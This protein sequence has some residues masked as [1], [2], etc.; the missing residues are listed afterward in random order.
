MSLLS[1]TR[2]WTCSW[3]NIP[4]QTTLLEQAQTVLLAIKNNYVSAGWT[5][6][7]SSNASAAG[8]DAVDRWSTI[9]DLAWN[10]AGNAHSWIVLRSPANYPSASG[11]IWLLLSCSPAVA[12]DYHRVRVTPASSAFSGGSTTASP[13]AGA[14]A[15]TGLGTSGVVQFLNSVLTPSS[16]HAL[17]NT[18]GD[19]MF[20]VSQQ[21]ASYAATSWTSLQTTGNEA[22]DPYPWHGMFAYS[23][24]AP[25][26]FNVDLTDDTAASI[27]FWID[28]STMASS[29]ITGVMRYFTPSGGS[30]NVLLSYFDS[31]GSDI[32]GVFPALPCFV[33]SGITNRQCI[34]GRWPDV[35]QAPQAAN[36]SQGTVVP[37]VGS[38]AAAI[39]GSFWVPAGGNVPVFA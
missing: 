37:Q 7:G 16:W 20:F 2:T 12:T 9:A 8:Y 27:Q 17:R 11:S 13:T 30:T 15:Y 35:Y 18:V 29:N 1:P 33:F 21:G 19:T 10:T 25:G 3:N 31:N 36:V 23:A 28:G 24:S 22:A 26:G 39:V 38:P 32:S 6:Q 5:V 14:N 4:A 34:R